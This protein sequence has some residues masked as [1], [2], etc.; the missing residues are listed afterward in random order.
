M[1]ISLHLHTHTLQFK[2]IV[3]LVQ[4]NVS[5]CCYSV[6]LTVFCRIYLFY[7]LCVCLLVLLLISRKFI[8]VCMCFKLKHPVFIAFGDC[9]FV[10]RLVDSTT[11]INSRPNAS[12]HTRANR[13]SKWKGSG[14]AIYAHFCMASGW[15]KCSKHI[16]FVGVCDKFQ[17]KYFWSEFQCMLVFCGS[18][19][20][21]L[22]FE[23]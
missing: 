5:D 1:I 13:Q 11:P 9:F 19:F 18:N 10:A 12:Q 23:F 3:L 7:I 22:E 6:G 14:I 15:V 16:C 17:C 2:N 4:L 20:L 8:Y 21:F